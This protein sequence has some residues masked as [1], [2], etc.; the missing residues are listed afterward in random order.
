[1]CWTRP[2]LRR[3]GRHHELEAEVLGQ[4]KRVA[5][6]F[7]RDP[8]ESD[9]YLEPIDRFAAMAA[10][11]CGPTKKGGTVIHPEEVKEAAA[12]LPDNLVRAVFM[13]RFYGHL[14]DAEE[15]K[16]FLERVRDRYGEV[17]LFQKAL[18]LINKPG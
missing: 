8:Y 10:S 16:S 3:T 17:L 18:H 15:G 14:N 11:L 5:L 2:L 1:M 4:V 13:S 6:M 9:R 7:A 12:V